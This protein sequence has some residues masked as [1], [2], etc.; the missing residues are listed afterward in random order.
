MSVKTRRV[1]LDGNSPA[2]NFT[3]DW[4]QESE[5]SAH[6]G[7][8][9]TTATTSDSSAGFSS[10][11]MI[12]AF[13]GTEMI[14]VGKARRGGDNAISTVLGCTIDGG[15]RTDIE[16]R[17]TG[18]DF[19]C[20]W[21]GQESTEFFGNL[22]NFSFA[23][24]LA[25]PGVLQSQLES[26]S[27]D[28]VWYLPTPDSPPVDDI[29]AMVEYDCTYPHIV[30]TSGNWEPLLDDGSDALVATQAGASATVSFTGTKVVWEGW[31]PA[32]YG[33]ERSSATYWLDGGE[34]VTFD[35]NPLASDLDPTAHGIK[36]IEVDGLSEEVHNLTVVFNG[37]STPL[38]LDH[39]LVQGGNFRIEDELRTS[40][41]QSPT[42]PFA[43]TTTPG[44]P[45]TRL[46]PNSSSSVAWPYL[47]SDSPSGGV[48][49]GAIAGGVVGGLTFVTLAFVVCFFA[50]R[51][52]KKPQ[53]TPPKRDEVRR[54]TASPTAPSTTPIIVTPQSTSDTGN[55]T[56][57]IRADQPQNGLGALRRTESRYGPLAGLS[58]NYEAV[59]FTPLPTRVKA[60][61]T[62][63]TPTNGL[64]E[65]PSPTSSNAANNQ[66]PRNDSMVPPNPNL[67]VTAIQKIEGV[68]GVQGINL[69]GQNVY[70]TTNHI[71]YPPG[72]M[73]T[74]IGFQSSNIPT[75]DETINS[76]W[77]QPHFGHH[78]PRGGPHANLQAIEGRPPAS[79]DVPRTLHTRSEE[80]CVHGS[81]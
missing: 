18:E 5:N 66:P 45:T 6:L 47:P 34:P 7:T 58:R 52:H 1:V 30:Y 77:P 56:H 32:G 64:I 23:P 74:G 68:T 60:N 3:G 51:K 27:I 22:H 39:L 24:T 79:I 36:L 61:D 35:L 12:F 31:T 48:S 43:T 16:D 73:P 38:V 80:S 67:P 41:S 46:T 28:S 14:L 37:P 15:T 4:K 57:P 75:T 62:S 50:T 17:G 71:Y 65:P 49:V 40:S 81:S 9:W 8:L 44:R 54:P 25:I 59:N 55:V 72:V 29:Q 70:H 42:H 53:T 11:G 2:F 19:A 63:P 21:K 33:L 10:H 26:V 78:N 20:V 76:H 69:A 13:Y